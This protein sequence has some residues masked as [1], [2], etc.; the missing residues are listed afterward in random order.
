LPNIIIGTKWRRMRMTGRVECMRQKR[1]VHRVLMDQ[2]HQEVDLWQA[3]VNIV[4][5]FK[6]YK[7]LGNSPVVVQTLFHEI[8]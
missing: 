6:F 4:M 7:I 3:L 1:N 2:N 8:S 5:T